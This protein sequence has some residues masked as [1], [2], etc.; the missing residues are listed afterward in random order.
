MVKL[1]IGNEELSLATTLR[2]AYALRDICGAKNLQ[3]AI[4]AIAQMDSEQQLELLYAAYKAANKENPMRKEEFLD[5]VLDNLGVFAIADAVGEVAEGL[6]YSGL[7]PEEVESK[8][9]MVEKTLG[10]TS[11]AKDTDTV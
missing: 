11:S 10:A 1:R 4:S 3:G 2:V 8:K 6:L 5:K 7:T 9:A